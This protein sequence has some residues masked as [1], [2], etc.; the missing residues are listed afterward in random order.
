MAE[1]TIHIL[2][3]SGVTITRDLDGNPPIQG[4]VIGNALNGNAFSWEN[5]SDLSL[6]FS[7]PL[8]AITFDDADGILRDDPFSGSTVIDQRLT[9]AVTI[10]GVTY[11]PND[12]TTRWKNPAPVNVEN[13][14]EVTLFDDGGTAY[15]MVGVSITQGYVTKVVGVTFDG[16]A[17][18]PGTTLH[19]IRGV[20]SYGGSGQTMTIPDEVVCFL[21]GTPIETPDGPRAIEDLA[22]GM[23]VLTLDN[24]A[25]P[26]R[27]IG[28]RTVCG[29]GRLAPVRI[30]AGVLGNRRDL[31]LSPNHRVLLRSGAAE[32][33]FGSH[34]VLV[35]AKALVDGGAIRRVP[36]LRA[37]YLHLMLDGHQM[38]FSEGIATESLF[39]GAMTQDILDAEA[40]A[41][42]R[43]IFPDIDAVAPELS[44]MG[45]TLT[46][47]RYLTQGHARGGIEAVR[48]C[49]A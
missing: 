42:L 47:A 6:T 20:S 2:A 29:L 8:V 35:P 5:P 23:S 17:P 41:E 32:L 10:D 25:R 14:Y 40:L 37:D 19:Y 24:G 34:E 3:K 49:P 16:A 4:D 21:A 1:R 31:Y 45:L 15:R 7:G 39:T 28:R 46:E 13:E 30:G 44:H 36:M 33:C 9:E 18:P 11:T 48:L 43:A 27:W 22:A 38:V 26:I 12:E